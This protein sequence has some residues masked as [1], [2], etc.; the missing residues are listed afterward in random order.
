MSFTQITSLCLAPFKCQCPASA[1]IERWRLHLMPYQFELRYR[2]RKDDTIPADYISRHPC[3]TES[4]DPIEDYVNYVCNS[5]VPK[6]MTLDE[7]RQLTSIDTVLQAVTRAIKT[8]RWNDARVSN[9]RNVQNELIT[10]NEI[11]LRGTR[12]VL[13]VALQANAVELAIVKTK[14]LLREKAWFPGIDCMAEK[15]VKSSLA[16]EAATSGTIT[17]EPTIA[18]PHPTAPWRNVSLDFLGPIPTGEYLLVVMDS[19]SRFSEV[20]IVT[21]TAATTVIPKL[22]SIF[23]RQGI[24]E[25]KKSDNS[26]P[27]NGTEFDKLSHHLGFYHRKITPIWQQANGEVERFMAPL[28]KAIRVAHIEQRRWK[29]ELYKFLRQ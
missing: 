3:S 20:E 18:T 16:C 28:M 23:S 24:P 5:A 25:L 2:P 21:S 22:D 7:V 6:T 13:P 8:G 4:S 12:I 10:C 27:F 9:F 29:L 1:R 26:P 17:P 14:K 11:M 19:Y 15:Q